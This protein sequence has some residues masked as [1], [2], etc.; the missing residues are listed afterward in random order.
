M[1]II[2]FFLLGLAVTTKRSVAKESL[3]AVLQDGLCII[4]DPNCCLIQLLFT[5]YICRQ[6]RL[7][8]E[9]QEHKKNRH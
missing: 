6:N 3:I 1:K 5:A 9:R 2:Y 8:E 7:G 4:D